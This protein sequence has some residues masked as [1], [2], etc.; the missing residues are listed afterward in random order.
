MTKVFIIEDEKNIQKEI[1]LLLSQRDDFSVIGSCTSVKDA[2]ATLPL[3]QLDLVIMDIELDDGQSF[4]ILQQ[5]PTLNFDIIFITAYNEFAIQAIKIGALDYLLKPIDREEFYMALDN[6]LAK[7]TKGVFDEQRSLL[8]QHTQPNSTLQRITLRTLDAIYFV[9]IQK[10]I[11][12]KGEGN[13]TTFFL[14]G[15]K[16]I[17]T[18]KPL[19]EYLSMLPKEQFIKT[20]QSYMVNKKHVDHYNNTYEIVMDNGASIPVSMRKKEEV[21]KKL[22]C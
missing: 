1:E 5:L 18:S 2:L 17:V 6:Y 16:E 21:L 8:L 22:I 7:S 3:L 20:H 15:G 9:D 14:S 19:R 10:I 12:C 13:Y 11:Y 4:E